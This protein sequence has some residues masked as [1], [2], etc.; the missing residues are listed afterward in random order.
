METI[1]PPIF[2]SVLAV[3]RCSSMMTF[4]LI[5]FTS[6]CILLLVF[7]FFRCTQS[8]FVQHYLFH[9]MPSFSDYSFFRICGHLFDRHLHRHIFVLVDKIMLLSVILLFLDTVDN[10]LYRAEFE[11]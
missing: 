6:S 10:K 7:F 3:L 1:S 4:S 8:L 11:P 9:S 5:Q 2:S